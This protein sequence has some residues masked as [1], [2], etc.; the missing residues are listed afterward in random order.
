MEVSD[1]KNHIDRMKKDH[2]YLIKAF[3]ERGKAK[4]VIRFELLN[5]HGIVT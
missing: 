2:I 3:P 1:K 5:V 4:M